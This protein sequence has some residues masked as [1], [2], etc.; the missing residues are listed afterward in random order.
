MC[1]HVIGYVCTD[2]VTFRMMIRMDLQEEEKN[3][4]LENRHYFTVLFDTVL[5]FHDS[6][7]PPYSYALESHLVGHC[8]CLLKKWPQWAKFFHADI[9]RSINIKICISYV[10][11]L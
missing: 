5:R 1:R 8:D 4:A 11:L 2:G 10:I 3:L 6:H 7:L 9:T